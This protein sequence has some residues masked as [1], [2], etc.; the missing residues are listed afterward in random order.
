[1]PNSI[2]FGCV[3]VVLAWLYNVGTYSVSLFDF[4][5]KNFVKYSTLC[6]SMG[7][8]GVLEHNFKQPLYTV[9]DGILNLL[10]PTYTHNPHSLLLNLILKT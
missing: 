8:S 4:V 6:V 1:M 10:N 9:K 2:I 3:K 7:F 5:Y